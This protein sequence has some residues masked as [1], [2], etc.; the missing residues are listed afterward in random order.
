M[1]EMIQFDDFL[2]LDMRVATIT[3]AEEHPRADKLLVLQV[4]LGEEQR[5]IIAGLRGY[6]EPA[7]LEG[8]QII[9][10]TNLAPR[11]MRGLE[12][13]GM[14]MAASSDD[15]SQVVLL[16]TASACTPGMKVS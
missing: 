9:V 11:N 2:K 8:R 6:Y 5:Q 1:A 13:Q 4:D 15:H 12:S 16:T 10:V 3:K 14:L 7:A